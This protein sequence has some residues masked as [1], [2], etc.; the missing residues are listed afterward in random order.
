MQH[1][2]PS[3]P[4]NPSACAQACPPL[5]PFRPPACLPAVPMLVLEGEAALAELKGATKVRFGDDAAHPSSFDA[6][7][8]PPVPVAAA[9]AAAAADAGAGTWDVRV[10]GVGHPR[11]G[12]AGC[13]VKCE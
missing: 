4:K 2:P 3:T 13:A 12:H 7:K 1:A 9:V 11:L 8:D 10:R 5:Q 6:V